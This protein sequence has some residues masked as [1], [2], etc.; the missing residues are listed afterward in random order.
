[1]LFR[2]HGDQL[3]MAA[4]LVLLGVGI[5]GVVQGLA[6]DFAKRLDCG[7]AAC[8]RLVPLARFGYAARGLATLC[9]GLFVVG[10]GWHARSSEARS[11]A[12]WPWGWWPSG[13]SASARPSIAASGRRLRS[14]PRSPTPR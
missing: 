6:Q 3:L 9:V 11:W 12:C 8:R 5:G 13:C 1:M 10:A 7:E 2:S 14:S 4:G